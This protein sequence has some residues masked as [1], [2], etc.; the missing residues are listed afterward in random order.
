MFTIYRLRT[1]CSTSKDIQQTA[2]AEQSLSRWYGTNDKVKWEILDGFC[3]K[4][5][6]FPKMQKLWK[7][8][9]IDKVITDYVMVCFYGPRC[10]KQ[11]LL[12]DKGIHMIVIGSDRKIAT[13]FAEST[14]YICLHWPLGLRFRADGPQLRTVLH[15]NNI[16]DGPQ[17]YVISLSHSLLASCHT[18]SGKKERSV[19]PESHRTWLNEI[20]A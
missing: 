18:C 3:R 9:Y 19:R 13:N 2:T 5:N 8:F 10:R 4:F 11:I 20:S 15:R 1:I 6:S 7:L 12:S 17:S 14:V 16:R